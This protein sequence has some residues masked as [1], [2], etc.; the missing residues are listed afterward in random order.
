VGVHLLVDRCGGESGAERVIRA[1]VQCGGAV[2]V[3]R[4]IDSDWRKER[5]V[6]D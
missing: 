2:M 3:D 5:K 4:W 1:G 6:V